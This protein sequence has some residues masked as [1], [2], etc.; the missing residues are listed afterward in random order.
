M[1]SMSEVEQAAFNIWRGDWSI[2]LMTSEHG[3]MD[4]TAGEAGR[5]H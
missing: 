4:G 5:Y 2:L 1:I 3:T